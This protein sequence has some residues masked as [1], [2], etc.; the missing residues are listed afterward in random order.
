MLATDIRRSR[1]LRK[2]LTPEERWIYVCVIAIA[3]EAEP[4]GDFTIHGEV[5]E[6]SDLADEAGVSVKAAASA[7]KKLRHI[8][9]L[10]GLDGVDVV[11]DFDDYNPAPKTD[12]T[13]TERQQRLRDRR[14]AERHA[15]TG[16]V[17]RSV[18]GAVTG[19]H[20]APVTAYEVEEREEEG[21]GVT[22]NAVTPPGGRAGSGVDPSLPPAHLAETD[23]PRITPLKTVLD[24][25]HAVKGGTPPS[26]RAVGLVIAAYPGRSHERHAN[27]FEA[28]W[29]AG[30]GANR[31]L[32]DVVAA[33]RQWVG[34]EQDSSPSTPGPTPGHVTADQYVAAL[35]ARNAAAYEDYQPAEVNS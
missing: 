26:V 8:G 5:V 2:H 22:A 1:K 10:E 12:S 25:V 15:V 27:D 14:R 31:T 30:A 35:N 3:G 7:L 29:T 33:Y 21:E 9:L 23:V 34:K 16:G 19:D 20:N 4:R 28:W 13:A 11:H 6:E 24:R 32:R 17:T 18:T